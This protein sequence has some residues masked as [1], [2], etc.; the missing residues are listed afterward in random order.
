MHSAGFEP[1]VSAS[2]WSR[3]TTQT[4]Y[5]GDKYFCLLIHYLALSF[6]VDS[7]LTFIP[8]LGV[9]SVWKWALFPTF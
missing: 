9:G 5:A 4:T 3:P 1:T 8:L 6:Y 7:F 2:K